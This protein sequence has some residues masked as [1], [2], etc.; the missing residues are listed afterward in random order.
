[1]LGGGEH[2][3]YIPTPR[4][5]GTTGGCGGWMKGE[6][7]AGKDWAS[8]KKRALEGSRKSKIKGRRVPFKPPAKSELGVRGETAREMVNMIKAEG[9]ARSNRKEGGN[10]GER[11]GGEAKTGDRRLIYLKSRLNKKGTACTRPEGETFSYRGKGQLLKVESDQIFCVQKRESSYLERK[12]EERM[13]CGNKRK[14]QLSGTNVIFHRQR[15]EG[16]QRNRT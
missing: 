14:G 8:F 12:R 16:R 5:E 7:K 2:Y 9:K 3:R 15:L 13:V 1:L 10:A 6:E 11:R 4:E